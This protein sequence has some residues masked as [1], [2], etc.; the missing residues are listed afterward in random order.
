VADNDKE[1]DRDRDVVSTEGHGVASDEKSAAYR[2]RMVQE[3]L[4]EGNP[5]GVK[6]KDYLS[7]RWLSG[8]SW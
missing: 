2:R 4:R 5:A 3:A 7:N 1:P 8:G 6:A